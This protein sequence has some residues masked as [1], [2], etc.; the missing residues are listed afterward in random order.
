ML[1]RI[2]VL[3]FTKQLS[4]LKEMK[5]KYKDSDSQKIK[6]IEDQIND[7]NLVLNQ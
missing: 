4:M 3:L 2:E 5:H 1:S 6:V 7:L